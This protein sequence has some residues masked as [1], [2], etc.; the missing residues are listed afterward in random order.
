MLALLAC[1]S[2]RLFAGTNGLQAAGRAA[3]AEN[4]PLSAFVKKV[5]AAAPDEFA[6][7]KGSEDELG[8]TNHEMFKGTLTPDA[9]SACT[10]HTR[11]GRKM[12]LPPLYSCRLGPSRTL[13]DATP[14]YEKATADLRAAFP[15]WK[16]AEKKTGD[17]SKREESWTLT[18]EQPGF[19]VKLNLFDWG[20]VADIFNK[21][22]SSEPGVS[23]DL[24]VTDTLPEK[25]MPKSAAAQEMTTSLPICKFIEKL[26]AAQQ[27]D[28]AAP[29]SA[30]PSPRMPR[31]PTAAR[32]GRTPKLRA[33]FILPRPPAATKPGTL[34][35]C[36]APR[37]WRR[38]S[39][40]MSG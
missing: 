16:F 25:E 39:R 6:L 13:A 11:R 29:R 15:N 37:Q 8:K 26:R 22:P 19:T 5:I 7:L 32:F 31:E 24:S 2:T 21:T 34:A 28:Y 17:E 30:P 27:N 35:K 14:V 40:S 20:R 12:E 23:V 38:S 33:R 1:A 36:A 4:T 10:L 3:L 18:A 9:L